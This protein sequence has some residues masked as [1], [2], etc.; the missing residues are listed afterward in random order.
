MRVCVCEAVRVR[1]RVTE[2]VPVVEDDALGVRVWLADPV[3]KDVADS[4]AVMVCE[5]RKRENDMNHLV[6]R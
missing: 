3:L 6:G 1:V 4:V 2:E 5:D